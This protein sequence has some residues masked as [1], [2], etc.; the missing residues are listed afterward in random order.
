[1]SRQTLGGLMRFI[2]FILLLSAVTVFARPLTVQEKRS[3]IRSLAALI[4]SQYGPFEYK[5]KE[6]GFQ[7]QKIVEHYEAL[8]EKATNVEY[9][10]LINKFVAEFHDSH[11][12]SSIVSDHI[13]TLG[14]FTDR[15]EGKVVIDEIDRNALPESKFPFRR[16]D[17]IVSLDGKKVEDLVQDLSKYVGM[18][19]PESALRIGSMLVTT[20]AASTVPAQTGKAKLEIRKGNS[21]VL[22]SVELDWISVGTPIIDSFSHGIDYGKIAIDDLDAIVPKGEKSFRCSPKSRI[23][24]P[25]DAKS[26][27]NTPF[28][29]YYYPTPKG[30]IGY[31]RIPHYNW[32]N[33]ATGA[34]EN[35]VRWRQYEYAVMELEKNTV[36]LIIDQDHNCGGQ[37]DMVEKMVGLFADKP[38]LGLQFQ[39]LATR[40]EYAS[41]Q[42][43]FTKD[44]K[45][46]VEGK[47]FQEVLNLIKMTW[48]KGTDR[49][50]SKTTFQNNRL[51]QPNEIR[52]T[53]PVLVLI[54]EMSG[55]GGDAFPAM[56][57]GIG[58]AKLFGSRT[59]GAGGHVVS[60]IALP[61]SGNALRMTKSLFFHP[62]GTAIE[63]NGASPD[64]QYK[65]THSDYVY[66]YREYRAKYTETLL[67]LLP[68]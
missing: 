12:G 2:S 54:D 46:T 29:A 10:Y 32:K 57:Q 21:T 18:G 6:Q 64:Y 15:V 5:Q 28:V 24:V 49:L 3:E 33:E 8:A 47:Y 30:N 59:M 58:R 44:M 42:E 48:E 13:T 9:Y 35:E 62:N 11:F 63:N 27:L 7:F 45:N 50:T 17:E 39:F 65:I 20:R 68:H 61:Y 52:Y 51:L 60:G 19:N 25:K 23:E 40:T 1:M 16:G 37:V 36:G 67:S 56:M 26:I 38:F 4:Q 22:D 43:W 66:G 53:K 41:F 14:F 55:S 34:M 31:L